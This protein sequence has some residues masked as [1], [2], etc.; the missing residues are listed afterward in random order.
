M[1]AK[2]LCC[3]L[4]N[5]LENARRHT[6]YPSTGPSTSQLSKDGS[7]RNLTNVA[8]VI[9]LSVRPISLFVAT[10]HLY[11]SPDDDHHKKQCK[12]QPFETS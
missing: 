6:L 8:T 4:Y 11:T 9:Q 7:Q 1:R 10:Q 2:P 5:Q 12:L 3:V